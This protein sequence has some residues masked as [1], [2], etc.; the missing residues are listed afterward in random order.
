M[1]EP[2]P[3]AGGPPGDPQAG[4]VLTGQVT[5]TPPQAHPHEGYEDEL[6]Q[7]ALSDPAGLEEPAPDPHPTFWRVLV[8]VLIALGALSIVFR[9]AR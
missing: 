9:S 5:G 4:P 6:T 7:A 3:T 2:T 1:D 8:V